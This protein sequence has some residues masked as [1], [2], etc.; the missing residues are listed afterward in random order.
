MTVISTRLLSRRG[1]LAVGSA[2]DLD[3]VE[4]FD[5]KALTRVGAVPGK[6][7]PHDLA[8]SPDSRWLA[9]SV[10]QSNEVRVWSVA[11]AGEPRVFRGH[12]DRPYGVLF[13][14]DSA[15][16]FSVSAREGIKAWD[17]ASGTPGVRF[18][19]P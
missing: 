11:G 5:A 17:V 4:L 8:V 16:L 1:T 12:T 6:A 19:L 18:E 9:F 15:T 7:A 14:P 3:R 13:S 10:P 2:S